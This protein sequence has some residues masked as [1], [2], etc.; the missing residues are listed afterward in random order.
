MLRRRRSALQ[1]NGSRLERL[2]IS[3]CAT[4]LP[5]PFEWQQVYATG[6]SVTIWGRF[7]DD[8]MRASD[9]PRGQYPQNAPTILPRNLLRK[10]RYPLRNRR[11]AG[12]QFLDERQVVARLRLIVRHQV[13]IVARGARPRQKPI[14]TRKRKVRR[15]PI[16]LRPAAK[17]H[18]VG[19]HAIVAKTPQHIHQYLR[20]IRLDRIEQRATVD[21][22]Q[23]A[24]EVHRMRR[25]RRRIAG[26]GVIAGGLRHAAPRRGATWP[27]RLGARA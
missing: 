7:C 1:Q 25:A 20:A 21:P 19:R 12:E 2:T 23:M 15:L 14:Q 3:C 17:R 22:N 5:N 24:I 4:R 13:A 18:A 9:I 10:D 8:P 16:L 6:L 11:I 26:L 27:W